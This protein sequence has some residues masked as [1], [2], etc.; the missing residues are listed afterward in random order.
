MASESI[1]VQLAIDAG[2]FIRGMGQAKKATEETTETIEDSAKRGGQA[3]RDIA[4]HAGGQLVAKATQFA[5]REIIGFVTDSI[6]AYSDLEESINAVSV[7]F[8]AGAQTILDFGETAAEGVG[9]ANSEFNQLSVV[10]GAILGTF[11]EDQELAAQETIKLTQRAADMASVFNTSVPEA[12]TAVQAA[13]RGETEPARRFGI[14]LD[15]MTIRARA[16]EL[17]LAATSA[18]VDANGKKVAALDLI[19]QQT[20]KTA[21]D[22]ANTSDSLANRQKTLGAQF[23]DAKAKIGEALAPA[24]QQLLSV[25][26]DLVP[27]LESLAPLVSLFADGL[28][29]VAKAAGEVL[30]PIGS[31]LTDASRGAGILREWFGD[32]DAAAANRYAEAVENVK[33]AIDDGDDAATAYANSLLHL[34]TN[35]EITESDIRKLGEGVEFAGEQQ[36]VAI[37]KTLELAREQGAATTNIRALEDALLDQIAATGGTVEETQALIDKYGIYARATSEGIIGTNELRDS[38]RDAGLR[39]QDLAVDVELSEEALKEQAEAADEA[40]RMADAARLAEEHLGLSFEELAE[41][42][43]E[44]ALKMA[45]AELAADTLGVEYRDL[46]GEIDNQTSE[47]KDA[48]QALEDWM[49]RAAEAADPMIRLFSATEKL[50]DAQDRYSEA[51][52]A[53]EERLDELP[54]LLN[55]VIS[56]QGSLVEA[57]TAAELATDDAWAA[58]QE[59]GIQAGLA[60]EEIRAA[61]K[62][63]GI[64]PPVTNA[65]LNIHTKYT[66]SGTPPQN[67]G[68]S[69]GGGGTTIT[70]F[71]HGGDFSAGQPIRVGELGPEVLIPAMSGSIMPNSTSGGAGGGDRTV[72]VYVQGSGDVYDDTSLALLMAGVTEEIE[73][74]GSSTLRG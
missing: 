48:T 29:L 16:V 25:G 1:L 53:G 19:Y 40:A 41:D 10:T 45:L 64:V 59:L 30:G 70:P 52:D 23:E 13:L 43:D 11:I 18:E 46:A 68:G 62:A 7:Q 69:G 8:G 2:N 63:L 36:G 50:K 74:A 27:V 5:S 61:A 57:Q 73:W 49:N 31:L 15:D 12:L 14:T 56:A 9:L 4:T 51:L 20:A 58:F 44:A 17:G 39:A 35:S 33:T 24:M 21:G 71:A 67:P 3:I 6:Q 42:T 55:D 72:Q 54:G 34:A 37:A 28:G 66:S 32:A 47:Q 65:N 38:Y 60:E 26:V 22:F